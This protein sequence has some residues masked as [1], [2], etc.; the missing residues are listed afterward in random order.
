MPEST[1]RPA[2]HA[3]VV[4]GDTN[5]ARRNLRAVVL[6][7]IGAV[8][9]LFVAPTSAIAHDEFVSSF[10]E[11]GSTIGT[12][13]TEITLSFSGELLTEP[14]SAVMEVLAPGGENVA[15]DAPDIN[16]QTATQHLSPDPVAGLFTVRW[17]VVS[18]D[19]HPISGEF[20]YTVEP[21]TVEPIPGSTVTTEPTSE[22]SPTA[23]GTAEAS[24]RGQ[25][26]GGGELLPVM[27]VLLGVGV[28]GGSLIVVLMMGRERRRRDKAA[29]EE[30]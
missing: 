13:P 15:V 2:R 25:P 27:A 28:V 8:G 5:P 11:A 12:S 30:S 21:I 9:L 17:K 23:T 26:S 24:G 10:P 16:G 18:S 7:V 3:D 22:P 1:P 19:G 6:A 20:A 14:G 4:P 29:G